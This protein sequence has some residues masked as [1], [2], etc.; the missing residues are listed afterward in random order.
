V[1]R[2]DGKVALI[3][4]TGVGMGRA[5][6][7]RFAGEG[8]VVVGCDLNPQTSAETER[9][10]HDA[11]GMMTASAPVDLSSFEATQEWIDG[12]AAT[13]GGI[14]VLYNNASLPVVG[15]WE[16]L[17]VDGW[18]AGIRNELDLVFYACKAAWPH[19]VARGGGSIINVASIAAIRGAA[20]FQQAAHGAAKGGVLSLTY[21]LA[22]AGGPHRIRA[23]AI[24]PGLI[25]TPS[26]EFLFA[27][28]ESPGAMLAATN[29]LGRVGEADDVAK[30]AAFLASDDAWYINA[31]AIPV[32]GG[33]AT[34]E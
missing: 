30:L 23:N 12:A 13:Y 19:L 3:T 11:G 28:P 7:L 22:A 4:G 18:H 5:A 34:I 27:T 6:A 16:E 2:L 20:F 14:D 25:R 21:H 32:D 9:L 10:V 31:S 1:T 15:P 26:T 24:M 8:A 29:P 33:Q 17:T